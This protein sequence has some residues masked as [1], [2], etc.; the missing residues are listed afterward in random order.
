M[1]NNLAYQI[2]RMCSLVWALLEILYEGNLYI[3][4]VLSK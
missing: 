3:I 1:I 2:A 4:F